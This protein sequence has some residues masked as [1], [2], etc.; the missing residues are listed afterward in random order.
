MDPR[1]VKNIPYPLDF[2]QGLL[3][4][5]VR[6]TPFL[7]YRVSHFA[8]SLGSIASVQEQSALEK[9]ST[10]SIQTGIFP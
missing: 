9:T 2:Y 7:A 10:I 5:A 4:L 1:A 8:F 6:N 3:V